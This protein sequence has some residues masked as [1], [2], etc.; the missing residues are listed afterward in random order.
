MKSE[1]TMLRDT[2]SVRT[3]SK[4]KKKEEKTVAKD[5]NT[6]INKE[7]I[8][9][10]F[11]SITHIRQISIL[12]ESVINYFAIGV[13][14][15]IYG[16]R[17]LEWF[18]INEED[19]MNFHLGYFL[20]SGIILYIIGIFNWYEGKGLI[21]LINFILSFLFIAFFFKN[22]NLG[23]YTVLVDN[24]ILEGIFYILLFCFSFVIFISSIGKR[25]GAIYNFDYALLFL[26][27]VF[28]FVDKFWKNDIVKKID[29]YMFIITG[30]IFWIT[31]IF[32]LI[33]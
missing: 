28:S 11:E 10:K 3:N 18:K 19:N 17:G 33:V 22:K 16:C 26:T 31:G 8:K 32:K 15:F 23:K 2:E 6:T 13:C 9:Q 12:S 21:F 24:D 4:L 29:M 14:F 7:E 5:D 27:F 30:A 25:I 1:T 20:F